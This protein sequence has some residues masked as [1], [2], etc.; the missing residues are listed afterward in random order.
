MQPYD[1]RIHLKSFCKWDIIPRGI[2]SISWFPPWSEV[3]LSIS[4]SSEL[5]YNYI[6]VVMQ[7][8]SQRAVCHHVLWPQSANE[9]SSFCSFMKNSLFHLIKRISSA[10]EINIILVLKDIKQFLP[11]TGHASWTK[12]LGN[13]LM[14]I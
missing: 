8:Y 12:P 1:I 3:A 14:Q 6:N 4:I 10:F 11:L 13:Q 9:N 7:K 2:G 5:I